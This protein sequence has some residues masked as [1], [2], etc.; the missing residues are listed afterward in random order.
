M[1]NK[2]AECIVKNLKKWLSV[3]VPVFL[4]L[5]DALEIKEI[6]PQ[7][8][9]DSLEDNKES[10]SEEG[11]FTDGIFLFYNPAYILKTAR[12]D[13]NRLKHHYLHILFHILN[14]DIS[15]RKDA[16]NKMMFDMFVDARMSELYK[17]LDEMGIFKSTAIGT[18][19]DSHE[20]WDKPYFEEKTAMNC[21]IEG[22][23]KLL[24]ERDK[25]LEVIV[26]VVNML[27]GGDK[28]KFGS[29]SGKKP[30][31]ITKEEH[32]KS[33][34]SVLRDLCRYELKDNMTDPEQFDYS[35]YEIG[36][37]D[38]EGHPLIEPNEDCETEIDRADIAIAIDTS[39]SCIED[40]GK[41]LT[42]VINILK[43]C[44]IGKQGIYV[45]ECDAEICKE[46]VIKNRDEIR[47]LNRNSLSGGGGTSFIPVFDRIGEL[48]KE[49]KI[50]RDF[51]GL[52]YF[53]DGYGEFPADQP[54]H[55]TYFVMFDKESNERIPDFIEKI[56]ISREE[57]EEEKNAD[58]RSEKHL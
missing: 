22:Y 28:T 21:G 58:K 50:S 32:K 33:Y 42:D 57:F 48:K 31:D 37:N 19:F 52:I 35:W 34:R 38:F 45:F 54:D 44:E 17:E 10:V 24:S 27:S 51:K 20:Y 39:G 16:Q 7:Q 40:G 46:T 29:I 3:L 26:S 15:K 9:T 56:L 8:P 41:F 13:S 2:K 47:G 49:G 30:F 5:I 12:E 4:P 23:G 6:K 53:T 36:M 14:G 1:V 25:R 43:E 11:L 18:S 55:K